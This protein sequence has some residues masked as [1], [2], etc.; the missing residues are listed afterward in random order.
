MK[1]M[2]IS[3]YVPFSNPTRSY[4]KP[5]IDG[6]KNAPNANDDDQIPDSRPK[7]CMSLG[8]PLSLKT[9]TNELIRIVL[10]GASC[11]GREYVVM[12]LQSCSHRVHERWY[13][14]HTQ[15]DSLYDQSGD[16]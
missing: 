12:H 8:K 9:E 6:P 11:S 15:R 10:V 4:R 13:T 2:E 1:C 14:D 3:K 5:A 16:D 7:V